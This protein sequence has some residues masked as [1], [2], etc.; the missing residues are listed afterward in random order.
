MLK[1]WMV[2]PLMLLVTT[3]QA[4]IYKWKDS[5]GVIRYSDVPPSNQQY[6]S[7]NNKKPAAQSA[8]PAQAA[9]PNEAPAAPTAGND[10]KINKEIAAQRRR[11]DAEKAKVDAQNKAAENKAKQENCQTA[12]ANL[13]NYQQGGRVYKMNADGEREYL[14]DDALDKAA[15]AAQKEVDKYC[16]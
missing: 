1:R 7:I 10:E 12:K 14:D 16:S 5:N 4:E 11:D 2:I 3:A 8:S 6:Q 9:N 15:A 13:L